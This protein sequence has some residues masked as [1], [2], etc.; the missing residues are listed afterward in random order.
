ML[1]PENTLCAMQ[2]G[3][4]YGFRAAE[5][6]VMLTMDKFPILMHDPVLLRTVQANEHQGKYVSD[7]LCRDIMAMDAGSWKDSSFADVKVPL[8]EEVLKYCI[9]NQIL[10]NIEIKPAPTFDVETGEVVGELVSRYFSHAEAEMMPLF[11]SFSFDSLLAV[12]KSAPHVPRAYLIESAEETPQWKEQMAELEAV[13]LNINHKHLT[14]DLA[15]EIKEAGYLLFVY[16]VNDVARAK[17]LFEMGVDA[18]CTD[19]LD[20]FKDFEVC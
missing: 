15:R 10:M 17:E 20:L 18:L 5:F 19:R 9:D 7:V 8:C 2:T 3:L 1:A 16:T 12:K 11:S 13:S 4:K 14:A 6:D